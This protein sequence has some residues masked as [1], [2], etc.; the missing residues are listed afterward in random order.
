MPIFAALG[1]R[2][3][4]FDYTPS[5]LESERM[6][7]EREGYEIEIVR[8]DMSRPLPFADGE[9]D[10]IFHPV[11]N[12][13]IE[14]AKP[15]WRECHRILKPGGRLLAGLDNGFGYAFDG[16]EERAVYSLP[17]NPLKN[18]DHMAALDPVEDGIQFSHTLEEQIRGQLQAGFQL[19]DCYEDTYGEGRLHDLNIPTFWATYAVKGV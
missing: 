19:V 16:A 8:G 13:Y 1:A 5:Q 18:P 6:V 10:L 7:A 12:C 9:F 3:T 2:C 17:F 15:L 4:V 11:S 14:E